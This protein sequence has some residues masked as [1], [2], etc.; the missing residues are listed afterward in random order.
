MQRIPEPDLMLDREQA[1]AYAS[2]DFSEPHERFIALV[3][4]K[5]PEL[6]RSGRALDL[7]CGPGD[8]TC[9]FARSHSDWSIDALDGSPAMLDLGRS[10][11]QEAGL[12]PRIEFLEQILP[13][14]SLPHN[15]YA[16]ILSN[17]LLH[18]LSD[19]AVLWS[20]VARW[21]R[22]S[23]S[24]FVMD[25]LRPSSRA[26]AQALVEMYAVGEPEVL[27]TDF[28][29]SLLAAYESSEVEEQLER[30]GLAGL[31]LEVISDR[32]F[33]VWGSCAES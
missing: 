18:H 15:D 22:P 2:A 1:R 9:R 13:T 3:G 5:L 7:G 19:P 28:L 17:S 16:L 29:N 21:L 23:C 31:N 10:K 12:S 20:T 26:D 14:G 6:S 24:V 32:H 27:R 25:L 11:V 33:I 4:E 8:I 30:A